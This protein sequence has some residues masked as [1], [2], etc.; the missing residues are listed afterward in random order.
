M[1]KSKQGE[2]YKMKYENEIIQGDCLEIMKG[3]PENTFDL[4][5]TDPPY[6]AENIGPN[7]RVYVGQKMKLSNKD[8]SKFCK[9][10]FRE[11]KRISKNLVFTPGISNTH[12][13]PAPFWQLCWHKPATVS[14]NRMGG[15]NAWEPIFIYGKPVQGQ[16]LGQDYIRQDTFNLKKG[17]ER[18]HPCPKLFP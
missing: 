17:P 6:N 5:I 10:W 3:I 13:Y 12:L 9:D 4:I 11:A 2:A 8:Y 7:K 14:F 1:P 18:N 16:R 15:F